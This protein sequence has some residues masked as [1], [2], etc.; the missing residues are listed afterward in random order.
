MMWMMV[1]FD[2]P[3]GTKAER[4]KATSFRNY[5]LDQ[6]FEMVQFSVYA[7]FCPT[8]EG[9]DAQSRDIQRNLPKSGKVSIL[10]FTDKQYE[11]CL[12][13]TGLDRHPPN[14]KP[15]QLALF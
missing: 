4:K 14:T 3:V 5:L 10:F 2:L 7:R 11:N 13:F 1:L 12:T 9:A 8:R 6:C 15:S